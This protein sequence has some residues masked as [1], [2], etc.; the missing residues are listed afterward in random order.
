[1][2]ITCELHGTVREAYG[3]KTAT[4]ALD[5][6][7]TIGDLLETLDDGNERVAPLV[8]NGDGEIRPHIAVH[9][10]GE[11]VATGEGAATALNDGD[12]VTILPSVSGGK[13]TLP[14]EMETV[15]LGNA[16]FEGLNNC[17]VL[18]LEDDA[19]LTLIDTGFP[20]DETRSELE[21]GLAEFGIDFS[22]IDRILLTHWHGDHAGLAAE[23]QE[24]SGCSVHVHVDDAPLV[25]GSEATQDMDDPA[26]R[27][28]LTRWGMPPQK[29]TELAEF[30]DANA[31][32]YG[33]PTVETFTDGDRFG[34]GS[35][36][37][38]AVHLPGHTVG[39]CGFAFDGHD[40]REL[41]SGD[42]L[43]PYY[44]PNVGGADVRVTEPLA[45]YLDT[46]VRIIDGGYERA[47]PGHRGA[48]VDPTGRAADIIDHHRERTERVVNVLADSPATPWEVSA[49]LFGA[50]HSIHILHGPGEAFAHLNHLEDAGLATRDGRTYELTTTDPVTEE[51]FPTVADRLRPGYEPVH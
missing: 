44:T 29:Q 9:V 13:P 33:R 35:V 48:I 43:L 14:F 32:T 26:F 47:W 31:A 18:G 20:T 6:G 49:E 15:R 3:A 51:L 38:E 2:Q 36:E 11:S 16:A 46:L 4:V 45:A 25:D 19:E 22:D 50:L 34:V 5:S 10:N 37:L 30:L 41:F 12:E 28:T 1:M 21:R 23:I 24:A 39:L 40:G 8:R 42:A 7:A 17:Y 27:D